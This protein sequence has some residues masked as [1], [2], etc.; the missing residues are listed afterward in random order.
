MEFVCLSDFGVYH[1]EDGKTP[2]SG[3]ELFYVPGSRR[4]RISIESALV[5]FD[6]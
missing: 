1:T 4:K 2:M 5:M 6:P 3:L